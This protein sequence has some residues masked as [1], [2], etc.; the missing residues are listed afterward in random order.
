VFNSLILFWWLRKRLQK[1]LSDHLASIGLFVYTPVLS[2]SPFFPLMKVI[3][4][5]PLDRPSH[6]RRRVFVSVR[7]KQLKGP[8]EGVFKHWS[9]MK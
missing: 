8:I 9:M 3:A 2:T 4:D 7:K 6:V 5:A 1:V